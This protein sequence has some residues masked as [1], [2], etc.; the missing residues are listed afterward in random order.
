[1]QYYSIYP[2]HSV[3]DNFEAIIIVIGTYFIYI[4]IALFIFYQLYQL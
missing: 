4:F 2:D 3:L 1:M